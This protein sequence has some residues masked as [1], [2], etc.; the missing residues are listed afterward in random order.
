MLPVKALHDEVIL[1][2]IK[3]ILKIPK[4]TFIIPDNNLAFSS[5]NAPENL[6]F[7]MNKGK[8]IHDRYDKLLIECEKRGL[9]TDFE[10]FDPKPLKSKGLYNNW[11][12][13]SKEIQY[14]TYWYKDIIKKGDARGLFVKSQV[15]N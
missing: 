13:T 14:N 15:T 12:P 7:F 3:T 6:K 1:M 9:K 10:A 5:I 8:W 4:S 2:E 11:K